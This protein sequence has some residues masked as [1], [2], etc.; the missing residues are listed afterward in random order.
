MQGLGEGWKRSRI[1]SP[2]AE[3]YLLALR[4]VLGY[5]RGF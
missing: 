5:L 2:E 4:R 1:A 3:R